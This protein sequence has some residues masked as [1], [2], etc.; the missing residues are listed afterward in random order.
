MGLAPS[1]PAVAR[2]TTE[3]IAAPLPDLARGSLVVAPCSAVT[4]SETAIKFP[5]ALAA[6]DV[7]ALT[8]GSVLV[9]PRTVPCLA[10]ATTAA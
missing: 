1:W 10:P 4:F 8:R 9:A 6:W 2:V 3:V 5:G 7:T